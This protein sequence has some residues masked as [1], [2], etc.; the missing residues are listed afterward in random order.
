MR[1]LKETLQGLLS[2]GLSPAKMALTVSAGITLGTLPLVWGTSMLCFLTASRLKL[3]HPA[4]QLANYF[5]WPLQVVLFL[6]FF[7]LGNCLFHAGPL[8]CSFAA[9]LRQA[10]SDWVGTLRM[11]GL[12]NLQAIGAWCLAAPFLGGMLYLV[13]FLLVGR[14]A[15]RW[16]GSF[17]P[18]PR[19]RKQ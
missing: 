10:R 17:G 11:F 2:Q 1:D 9:F 6:P 14:I 19:G 13:L 18:V 7:R 16:K 5:S 12:A 15:P 8:P 3:N 4:M